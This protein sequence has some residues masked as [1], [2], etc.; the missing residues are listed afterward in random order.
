MRT[1]NTTT[2]ASSASASIDASRPNPSG[3]AK[4][5]CAWSANSA[6]TT[7]TTF[8]NIAAPAWRRIDSSAP[9]LNTP[10]AMSSVP[11]KSF[12][13]SSRNPSPFV[14]LVSVKSK[15]HR[16]PPQKIIRNGPALRSP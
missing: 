13:T 7:E 15:T 10:R 12:S 6:A 2:A 1:Q 11:T 4:T 14:V 9:S 3:R 5:K 8:T 16:S